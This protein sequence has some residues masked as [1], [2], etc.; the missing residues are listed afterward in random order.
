MPTY[1]ELELQKAAQI[2][3]AEDELTAIVSPLFD[4]FNIESNIL[5]T[6]IPD[7]LSIKYYKIDYDSNIAEVCELSWKK[8]LSKYLED[9]CGIALIRDVNGE[10]RVAN[11]FLRETEII[12]IRDARGRHH[13]SESGSVPVAPFKKL[14]MLREAIGFFTQPITS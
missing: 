4:Q 12:V 3:G 11:I 8:S 9:E 10:V 6:T 7:G 5:N 2:A 13:F 14:E 1:T